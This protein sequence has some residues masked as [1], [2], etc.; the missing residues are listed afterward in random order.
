MSETVAVFSDKR[1]TESRLLTLIPLGSIGGIGLN[2]RMKG[3][4]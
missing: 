3:D 4:F 1:N 2:E